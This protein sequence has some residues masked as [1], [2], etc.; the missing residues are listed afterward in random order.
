MSVCD[1]LLFRAIIYRKTVSGLEPYVIIRRGPR[2]NSSASAISFPH[3]GA[4]VKP[5]RWHELKVSHIEDIAS[6]NGL[7]SCGA[8][9]KDGVEAL[10][11]ERAGWVLSREKL[12]CYS[13][14]KSF[15]V[16]T[17]SK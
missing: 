7:E 9:R 8:N 6:H 13:S 14:S 1:N 4:P 12:T 11:E 10:T 17:L 2:S 5:A 15:R 3:L 16:L